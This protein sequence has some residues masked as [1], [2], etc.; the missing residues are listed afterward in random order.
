ME[1]KEFDEFDYESIGEQSAK[2]ITTTQIRKLLTGVIKIANKL[3]LFE[4]ELTEE[5]KKDIEKLRIQFIYQA[6]R[7]GEVKRFD[8]TAKISKKLKEI[9]TKEE[10][11]EFH[12][13]IEGVVAYHRYYGGK[14]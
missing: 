4:G 3:R 9:Q 10:F 5:I 14:D 12:R 1:K 7:H 6:G 2:K 11:E 13:F 8:D